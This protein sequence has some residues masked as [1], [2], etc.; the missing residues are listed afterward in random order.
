MTHRLQSVNEVYKVIVKVCNQYH[1]YH[2]IFTYVIT[3][4]QIQLDLKKAIVIPQ[5]KN[6]NLNLNV[7]ANYRQLSNYHFFKFLEK[8][9][10]FQLKQHLM[11][12]NLQME[13]RSD[14]GTGFSIATAS[15]KITDHTLQDLNS[16][17]FTALIIIDI[18]VYCF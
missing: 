1:L 15:I 17:I 10:A 16:K 4:S 8:L 9:V 12:N 2:F 7:L 14:Y 6:Y 18:Y 13:F 3:S 11:L 5:L